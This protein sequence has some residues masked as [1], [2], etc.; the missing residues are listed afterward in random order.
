MLLQRLF[1]VLTISFL[2]P[3]HIFP[4]HVRSK[5]ASIARQQA[6]RVG[7]RRTVLLQTVRQLPR[8]QKRR[9]HGGDRMLIQLGHVGASAW[10]LITGAATGVGAWVYKLWHEDGKDKE[11]EQKAQAQQAQQARVQRDAPPAG[12][13]FGPGIT[14]GGE[15]QQVY[16]YSSAGAGAGAG[17]ARQP[18]AAQVT[19]PVESKRFVSA[20]EE[21]KETKRSS[22]DAAPSRISWGKDKKSLVQRARADLR[23]IRK[24]HGDLGDIATNPHVPAYIKENINSPAIQYVIEYF[25]K[26]KRRPKGQSTPSAG[27]GGGG[28]P[29]D[30]K[31]NKDNKEFKAV[32]GSAGAVEVVRRYEQH[33]KHHQNSKPPISPDPKFPH[34]SLKVAMEIPGGDGALVSLCRSRQRIDIF[35]VTRDA[36]II[37]PGVWHGYSISLAE[38]TQQEETVKAAYQYLSKEGFVRSQGIPKLTQKALDWIEGKYV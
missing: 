11:K 34:Q 18:V 23:Q 2:I 3:Q 37:R 25:K 9:M 21:S 4:L 20:A 1:V 10:N 14:W 29:K 12:A 19:T 8:Q 17:G 5:A 27:R 38:L 28:S 31:D 6:L 16:N 30:P 35:L 24:E 7:I 13:T 15:T 26:L 22:A 33:P 32:A 36:G